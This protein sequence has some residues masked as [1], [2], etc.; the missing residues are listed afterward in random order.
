MRNQSLVKIGEF[1]Q[2]QKEND[3]V[4]AQM[5]LRIQD[6]DF[7][8][9]KHQSLI[10]MVLTEW[11]FMIGTK[12]A[13]TAEENL[14]NAKFIINEYT[15]I[16]LEEIRQ[17]MRWSITNKLSID[18][19][20]YGR[21]APMYIAKVLNCY[22]NERDAVMNALRRKWREKIW[23]AEWKEKNKPLPYEQRVA[24]HK[25]FLIRHL[26]DMKQKGVDDSAGQLC[27]NFLSRALAVDESE[28]TEAVKQYA[29]ERLKGFQLRDDYHFIIKNLTRAETETKLQTYKVSYMKTYVIHQWLK[30]VDN[31]ADFVCKQP[32]KIIVEA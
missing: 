12:E 4:K 27:W 13:N 2:N 10:S 29:D 32:E 14:I 21:F 6:Y 24:E 19:T 17:A 30:T 26:N 16:T 7:S 8:T 25:N 9:T 3:I 31:V 5:A 20:L 1:C 28:F 11:A 22:L 23:D 18:P 15:D